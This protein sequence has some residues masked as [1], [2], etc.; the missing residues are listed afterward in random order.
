M[1]RTTTAGQRLSTQLRL[2]H[3]SGLLPLN[4]I[5][6]IPTCDVIDFDYPYWHKR[7]DIPASCSGESMAKVARVMLHWVQ[8]PPVV[9]R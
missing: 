6:K 8:N 7:N 3:H 5:A 4:Q 2:R 1:D 9:I